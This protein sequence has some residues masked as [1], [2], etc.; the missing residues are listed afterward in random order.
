[1]RAFVALLWAR[2][3]V[4]TLAF[5]TAVVAT[6]FFAVRLVL[7][8]PPFRDGG[9][10]PGPIKGWMTPRMIVHSYPIAPERLAEVLGL[11][12][13]SGKPRTL[14]QIAFDQGLTVDEIVARIELA[15]P[16]KPAGAP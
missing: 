6:L 3:P 10:A 4:V 7:F 14:E 13:R 11:D 2:Y 16:P 8:P 5:L 9:F 15:L 1:M 12:I